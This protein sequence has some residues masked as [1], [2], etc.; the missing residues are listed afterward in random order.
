MEFSAFTSLLKLNDPDILGRLKPEVLELMNRKYWH[1]LD[2]FFIANPKLNNSFMYLYIMG[3]DFPQSTIYVLIDFDTDL[4]NGYAQH[5]IDNDLYRLFMPIYETDNNVL[6]PTIKN[7]AWKCVKH[8]LSVARPVLSTEEFE[9]IAKNRDML[10][11][12]INL[13]STPSDRNILK[14]LVAST[15]NVEIRNECKFL[16]TSEEFNI[17][18]SDIQRFATRNTVDNNFILN[19]LSIY[20]MHAYGLLQAL[21]EIP[22]CLTKKKEVVNVFKS[23][24]KK[25]ISKKKKDNIKEWLAMIDE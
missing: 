4:L 13:C 20:K 15:T 5:V 19:Y 22:D 17:P 10:K 9:S 24:L 23:K 11:F 8:V 14:L 18:A 3:F 1:E 25:I 2:M 12:Y 7:R 6:L 16:I 21:S